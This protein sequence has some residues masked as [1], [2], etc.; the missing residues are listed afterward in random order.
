MRLEVCG[1][2]SGTTEWPLKFYLLLSGSWYWRSSS[3]ALIPSV[4]SEIQ[5][6]LTWPW[7]TIP[8]L[9]GKNRWMNISASSSHTGLLYSRMALPH[10]ITKHKM[11]FGALLSC[12]QTQEFFEIANFANHRPGILIGFWGAAAFW[13]RDEC[14]GEKGQTCQ[15]HTNGHKG[16]VE[17]TCW[18]HS[19]KCMCFLRGQ[20]SRLMTNI[21]MSSLKETK[22]F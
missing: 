20:Q 10:L 6:V 3:Q 11:W 18:P 7:L 19:H 4:Q 2:V 14:E 22:A 5:I 9:E 17:G 16:E 21:N 1:I 12:D 8:D 15:I 13:M